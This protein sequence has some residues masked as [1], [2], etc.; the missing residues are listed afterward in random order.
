LFLLFILGNN[1]R[2]NT[3]KILPQLFSIDNLAQS[4]KPYCL[5]QMAKAVNLVF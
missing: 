1:L 5:Q 2:N 3:A 4:S